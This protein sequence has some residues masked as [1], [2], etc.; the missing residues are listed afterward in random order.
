[1]P[2][3]AARR[4]DADLLLDAEPSVGSYATDLQRI[5]R[6]GVCT[7]QDV[8]RAANVARC[9]AEAHATAVS[10]DGHLYYGS[11]RRLLSGAEGVMALLDELPVGKRLA[12]EPGRLSAIERRFV[13][14]RWK[15][16]ARSDR[17]RQLHGSLL[18]ERVFVGPSAT[19]RLL[20]DETAI[21]GD[22][23]C[24]VA[25]FACSYL[26]AAVLQPVSW[27]E[28]L[29]PLW[30]GFWSS[31]LGAS[32]DHELLDVAPF[33]VAWRTLQIAARSAERIEQRERLLTFTEAT[34]QVDSFDPDWAGRLLR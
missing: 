25:T 19:A 11:L 8:D 22:A 33:F 30:R 3:R 12:F 16:R 29:S 34:L 1:M 21:V 13:A 10:D 4:P 7:E 14:W 20:Y 31:Y 17:L 15:L 2:S 23:A 24:D 28:G 6:E 9:L 26:Q 5:V 27:A 18:P 32:G